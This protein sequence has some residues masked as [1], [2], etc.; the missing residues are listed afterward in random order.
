[1]NG[2]TKYWVWLSLALG[3]G[4]KVDEI[5]SAYP[6]PSK[7]FE[8]ETADRIISGVFT[9]RQIEKLEALKLSDAETA[10]AV[11]K[12]N[13]W[14]VVTPEDSDYPAGLRK[15]PDMPIVLY[16]DGSLDCLKG[17]VIIGVVGTRKPCHEST[18]IAR[19]ISGD[20]A[21]AGAVV[22]SGGALG[23]DSSAHEG[24]IEAG[25]KTVCV[26]GCGLGVNYLMSNEAMR[27]SIREN[28]AVISEFPPLSQASRMTFPIRNRIISGLCDA[29]IVIEAGVK[30]GSLI[31][32]NCAI[33]Q[34]RDVFAPP[35]DVFNSSYAGAN[36]LIRDGARPLLSIYDLITE[37]SVRYPDKIK[38]DDMAKA[39]EYLSGKRELTQEQA[40]E[41]PKTVE[42]PHES[43]KKFE[44]EPK[45]EE[46]R[47]K[48]L[49]SI[50][51]GLSEKAK[52]IYE[53]MGEEPLF[54][55]EI[56]AKTG[57]APWEVVSSM[58]ELE[59]E[60]L[61]CLCAGKRYKKI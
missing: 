61:V 27:R 3:A 40:K 13:G 60:D 4:A 46:F 41:E 23:I 59:L 53:S 7:L 30:S 22:V 20:L 45:P 24:A 14:S 51:V 6:D 9:R 48:K 39:L 12:K 16:V 42:R 36:R 11:C 58:T 25:G 19:R 33:E 54:A 29:T 34:G 15:L 55:D 44:P 2:N 17:K 31:T 38:P 35:G 52:K 57:F 47:V 18:V 50:P 5:L 1:M 32:A 43:V 49:V 28:G 10:I 56:A 21:K 8:E 37:Y 26:M